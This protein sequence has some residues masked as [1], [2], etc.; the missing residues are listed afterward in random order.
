MTKN[1][2]LTT[3]EALSYAADN[4]L[5]R[6]AQTE[7]KLTKAG[8]LD[9]LARGIGG[10]RQNWGGIKRKKHFV[11]DGAPQPAQ[12]APANSTNDASG[13]GVPQWHNEP[14]GPPRNS[15]VVTTIAGAGI[16]A[17]ELYNVKVISDLLQ[18]RRSWD[19]ESGECLY[20]MIRP[21]MVRPSDEIY[22]SFRLPDL[23]Q[24]LTRGPVGHIEGNAQRILLAWGFIRLPNRD[25]D[26]NSDAVDEVLR[27]TEKLHRLGWE[28]VKLKHFRWWHRSWPTPQ[29]AWWHENADGAIGW[30][31]EACEIANRPQTYDTIKADRK[32]LDEV[33]RQL[34][35]MPP[36]T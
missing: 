28:G 24:H 18:G 32:A 34:P 22:A 23:L 27:F 6:F 26:A 29:A 16:T 25:V 30:L 31:K 17:R 13:S 36:Q 15:P 21:W 5:E 1:T 11:G 2:I 35:P 10:P 9:A 33:W 4:I 12:S 3:P 7:G 8:L 19:D 14:Y 20:D